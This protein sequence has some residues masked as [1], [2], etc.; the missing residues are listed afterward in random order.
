MNTREE[1]QKAL[2]DLQAG[3][4]IRAQPKSDPRLWYAAGEKPDGAR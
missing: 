2:A 3:T 4:F 1:I